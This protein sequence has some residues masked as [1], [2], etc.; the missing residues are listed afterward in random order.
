MSW[1]QPTPWQASKILL[2]QVIS[3]SSFQTHG[4]IY[5]LESLSWLIL[6]VH[7]SIFIWLLYFLCLIYLYFILFI[8]LFI[9]LFIILRSFLQYI[10]LHRHFLKNLVFSPLWYSFILRTNCACLMPGILPD[11]GSY[12]KYIR[13]DPY[14]QRV[15][16]LV[17]GKN[18]Q[19][20]LYLRFE[21][22]LCGSQH[23]YSAL[24]LQWLWLDP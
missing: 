3:V 10:S 21:D 8:I 20:H 9:Y 11:I 17:R 16:S 1:F 24:L 13:W 23:N 5:L 15:Y 4:K 18:T 14:P 7:F 12:A 19:R 22:F 2:S 6:V